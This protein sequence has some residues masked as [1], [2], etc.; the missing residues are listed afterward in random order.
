M[1]HRKDLPLHYR[2]LAVACLS[3][4]F[5]AAACTPAILPGAHPPAPWSYVGADGPEHWGQL[6]ARYAACAVGQAQTPVALDGMVPTTGLDALDFTYQ[7]S[8]P[9]VTNN[10]H[11]VQVD[12]PAG[13]RLD[14]GS[15]S[16][17]LLQY[18]FHAPSEHTLNGQR[19]PLELHFVHQDT[20]GNLA[21]VGVLVKEGQANPAYDTLIAALPAKKGDTA[22]LPS[23]NPLS[24]LPASRS[25]I[26]YSGSLTTPPCTEG[27][28]W[29]VLDVPTALS[30]GQIAA[31]T[32]LYSGNSRPLQPLNGRSLQ[33][34]N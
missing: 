3:L 18:H 33:Q 22:D 25:F 8:T 6:D 29:L 2:H 23:H 17:D 30:A 21:V 4:S 14:V 24:L 10:G 9:K 32:A 15:S 28:R 13:S 26:T 27:L 19:F 5:L 1:R 20:S 34:K 7:P 12:L 31:F 11:T 16:Y